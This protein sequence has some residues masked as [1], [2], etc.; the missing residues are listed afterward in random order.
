[1]K[2]YSKPEIIFDCFEL[3]EN[4]ASCALLDSGESGRYQCAVMI[5]DAGISIFN[6]ANCA[7]QPGEGDQICY[8]VPMEGFNVFVS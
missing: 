5:P 6:L 2:S 3:A 8:E 7:M 1:M 4:I